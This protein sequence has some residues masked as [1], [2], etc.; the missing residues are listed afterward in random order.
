[1][2]YDKAAFLIRGTRAT[3]NFP[4]EIVTKAMVETNYWC[5]SK[6]ISTRQ[7]R[8]GICQDHIKLRKKMEVPDF[9][10]LGMDFNI[11]IAKDD[12]GMTAMSGKRMRESYID[13]RQEVGS[14]LRILFMI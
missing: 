5:S 9:E 6:L 3:L 12:T 4:K 14:A 1:M 13:H 10:S 8:A 2:A 7:Q 11:Y